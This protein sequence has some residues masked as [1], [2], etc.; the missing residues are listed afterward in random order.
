SEDP[1]IS[2]VAVSLK[3][4]VQD[5]AQAT[6]SPAARQAA[7]KPS[8][9][10]KIRSEGSIAS[11]V[12]RL[13]RKAG[14]TQSSWPP[15]YR[16]RP[17]KKHKPVFRAKRALTLYDRSRFPRS[18]DRARRRRDPTYGLGPGNFATN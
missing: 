18:A 3:K 9:C 5:S 6:Q 7:S 4:Q 11:K 8:A 10:A 16:A 1:G 2:V 14:P 15:T 13:S 17:E 12:L